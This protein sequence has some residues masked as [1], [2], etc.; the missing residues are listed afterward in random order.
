M[1]LGGM[2][3]ARYRLPWILPFVSFVQ[4]RGVLRFVICEIICF[5]AIYARVKGGQKFILLHNGAW[6][7]SI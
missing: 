7:I 3:V 1:F 2:L 5:A 6:R 4:F